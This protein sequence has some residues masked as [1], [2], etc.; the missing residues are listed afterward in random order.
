MV[1]KGFDAAQRQKFVDHM[2]SKARRLGRE[3]AVY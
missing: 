3:R 2:I 1:E